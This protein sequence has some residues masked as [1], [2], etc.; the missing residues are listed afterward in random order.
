[1][2]LTK[3]VLKDAATDA[4]IQSVTPLL[5]GAKEDIKQFGHAIIIDLLECTDEAG[6]EEVLQQIPA[7]CE[8]ERVRINNAVHATIIHIIK[9][10]GL[11]LLKLIPAVI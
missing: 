7:L 2:S 3:Q 4:L 6:I 11:I 5:E 8:L 9:N 10:T 1:M